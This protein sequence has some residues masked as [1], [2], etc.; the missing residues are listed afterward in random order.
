MSRVCGSCTAC[1]K[2]HPIPEINKLTGR[3]CVNC[4]PGEG[5]KIYSYRPDPCKG[6]LC[7][8]LKGM[9]RDE[10][11]PDLVRHVMDYVLTGTPFRLGILQIFEV[12]KGGFE[13]PN[14]EIWTQIS[15]EGGIW[16]S[17]ISLSGKAKL[18][19]PEGE[20]LTD[21]LRAE[22]KRQRLEIRE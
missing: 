7:A 13:H 22:V 21:S 10:D 9:G 18:F 12:M 20:I 11:R 15:L 17:H 5:C 6:F 19:V 8:W 4:N 14:I 3:W 16:V 2:T 1:C